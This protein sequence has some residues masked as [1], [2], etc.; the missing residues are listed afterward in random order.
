MIF[1]SVKFSQAQNDTWVNMPTTPLENQVNLGN[2]PVIVPLG[3]SY[4][5]II[6]SSH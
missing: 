4:L 1:L 2:K 3:P 5:F 6:L